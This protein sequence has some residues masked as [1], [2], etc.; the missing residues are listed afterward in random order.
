MSFEVLEKAGQG[1][2]PFRC[3]YPMEIVELDALAR[4]SGSQHVFGWRTTLLVG[5]Y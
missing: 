5:Y 2:A 1:Q 4:V 3:F